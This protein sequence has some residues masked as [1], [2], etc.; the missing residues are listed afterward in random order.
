[1]TQIQT[2]KTIVKNN[3]H[4][5][6]QVNQPPTAKVPQTKMPSSSAPQS[7]DVPK[8]QKLSAK[9]LET[10]EKRNQEIVR[11]I[12]EMKYL[13]FSQL[14]KVFFSFVEGEKRELYARSAVRK[15]SELE[16]ITSKEKEI[17]ESSL[18]MATA[19]GQEYLQ[20][21]A[22]GKRVAQPVGRV[23]EPVINHD[24]M[25]T[26]IRQ[27]FEELGLI[28]R[29]FSEQQ[30]KCLPQFA[31]LMKDL[32]DAIVMQA[33]GRGQFLELEISRKSNQRYADRISEYRK[34]LASDQ[35]KS[36][37]IIGVMF[38]CVDEKVHDLLKGLAAKEKYPISVRLVSA[39][40]TEKVS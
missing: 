13:K 34:L 18:L 40:L 7:A 8:K 16:Y 14:R 17:N 9:M 19:K 39:Y 20:K 30:L 11:Y 24:L 15:L 2:N 22:E 5:V 3:A 6:R 33:N 32:P 23:W 31:S 12:L 28:E 10:I 27:K 38:L 25:L 36:Q 4:F 1:M 37:N 21:F 35:V 29:W 26:D